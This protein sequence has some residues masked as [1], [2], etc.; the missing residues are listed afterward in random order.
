MENLER[1]GV[2]VEATSYA[3]IVRGAASALRRKL[4]GREE[5]RE[6]VEDDESYLS[7]LEDMLRLQAQAL[8]GDEVAA[9]SNSMRSLRA[10]GE[11]YLPRERQQSD[12]LRRVAEQVKTIRERGV[13]DREELISVLGAIEDLQKAW[14]DAALQARQGRAHRY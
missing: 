7:A 3:D 11:R 4:R 14:L 13:A 2:L 5:E 12:G 1:L 6:R 10:V 9:G 8:Q